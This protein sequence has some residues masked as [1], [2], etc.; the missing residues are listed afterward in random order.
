MKGNPPQSCQVQD[1]CPPSAKVRTGGMRKREGVPDA[2]CSLLNS[3]L[4]AVACVRACS[5]VRRRRRRSG[6]GAHTQ[7]RELQQG[8]GGTEGTFE[9]RGRQTPKVQEAGQ[10]DGGGHVIPVPSSRGHGVAL[11]SSHPRTVPFLPVSGHWASRSSGRRSQRARPPLLLS[12]RSTSL[13]PPLLSLPLV[14]ASLPFPPPCPAVPVATAESKGRQKVRRKP[15]NQQGP[16]QAGRTGTQMGRRAQWQ[17][18]T[19]EIGTRCPSQ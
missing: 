15:T 6:L 5:A 19:V 11:A 1:R 9:L 8:A 12:P 14:C 10:Q 13:P 4:P 16:Q 17:S 3:Q 7:S 2:C 18:N